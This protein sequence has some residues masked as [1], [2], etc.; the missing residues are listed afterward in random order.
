MWH[1][2][3]NPIIYIYIYFDGFH[4]IIAFGVLNTPSHAM[5]LMNWATIKKVDELRTGE[6][7][8][9]LELFYSQVDHV[10][11]E[12][13]PKDVSVLFH[14]YIKL[15]NESNMVRESDKLQNMKKDT[16]RYAD[17]CRLAM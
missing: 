14:Y 10:Q 12:M 7:A 6:K 5:K 9:S 13:G 2:I 16:A 3:E 1:K 8:F 17:L 4:I 11:H 15:V